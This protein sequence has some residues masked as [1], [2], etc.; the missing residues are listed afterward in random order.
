MGANGELESGA[1]P[2]SMNNFQGRYAI[3]H[4]WTGPIACEN[5]RRGVWG[6]PP[7]SV[8]ASTAPKAAVDLAFVRRGGV[9][10]ASFI[11]KPLPELDL[12]ALP[13]PPSAPTATAPATPPS[14]PGTSGPAPIPPTSSSCGACNVGSHGTGTLS[15]LLALGLLGAASIRRRRSR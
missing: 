1:Q 14:P 9:Q 4:P 2:S 15:G 12:A 8:T 3:R 6:G 11:Q 5:P 13:A 7:P 10:L